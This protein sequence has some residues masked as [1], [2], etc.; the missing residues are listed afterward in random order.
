MPV[1]PLAF[2]VLL[3]PLAGGLLLLAL[4]RWLSQAALTVIGGLLLL[5]TAA[6]VVALGL[7]GEPS[8]LAQTLPQAPVGLREAPTAV[9]VQPPR[10]LTLQPSP[11][12]TRTQTL[13][14]T[15]TP[16]PIASVTVAVR[17]GTSR[18]GLAGRTAER[19]RAQGFVIVEVEND[20]QA[21]NRPHTLI[22]DRGDHPE[23]RRMLAELLGIASDYVVT[24]SDE[25]ARADIVIVLG[26][27]FQE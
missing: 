23:A 26:D 19:L 9:W 4:R 17:N 24:Q 12:P 7:A 2:V 8:P 16:N 14:P 13:T 18:P 25:P 11:V 10:T 21:G 27:D 20:P 1:S 22:L 5:V 3:L 15:A 6:G